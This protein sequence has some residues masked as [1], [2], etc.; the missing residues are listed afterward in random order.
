MFLGRKVK[1]DLVDTSTPKGGGDKPKKDMKKPMII[2]GVVALLLVIFVVVKLVSGGG[3]DSYMSSMKAIFT[4]ELGTF[5]YVLNVQTGAEGTI[6]TSE[7]TPTASIDELEGAE[8]SDAEG[9]GQESKYEFTD[10][11]KYAEVQSG[12]WEY[13]VF[14]IIIEGCTTSVEPLATHFTVSL[15]TPYSNDKFTD[16]T[17]FNGNYYIDVEQM[18]SWL[19]N[20]KD[21]YLTELGDALPQGSKYLIIPEAEFSIPSR[22]AE[23]GEKDFSNATGL[24]NMYQRFLVGYKTF[25][26]QVESAAG[27]KAFSTGDGTASMNISGESG[28]AVLNALKNTVMKVGDFHTSLVNASGGLY[29]EQQKQQAMRETDNI[30]VAFNDFNALLNTS[31]FSAAK[32]N[33][34]GFSRK[35]QNGNGNSTI[36]GNAVISFVLGGTDYHIEVNAMR[37]GDRTDVVLP[38]GSTLSLNDLEQMGDRH[39][40]LNTLNAIVDYFNFT[41]IKLS[42]ELDVT[43]ES[44]TLGAKQS[45]VDLVN[46]LEVYDGYLT[47]HNLPEYL[48]KY[49]NYEETAD[50]S[51]ADIMNAKLVADFVTSLNNVTGGLVIETVVEKEVEVEQYPE[52]MFAEQGIEFTLK[53]DEELSSSNM[54]V[55]NG[56]AINKGT[57][58]LQVDLT[59][60]SLHTLLSSVY[61][62]NNA[63]ILHDYD[64]SF[65]TESLD[66]ILEMPQGKWAQFTLYF[67]ISDDNGHMDLFLGGAQKGAVV[68]Y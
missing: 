48:E 18:R 30:I 3:K 42:Q 5:K 9:E 1:D 17:C 40:V 13:P 12:D 58:D 36:E 61:P 21:S 23:A 57:S 22:Y 8:S 19:V 49:M 16:V 31:D 65:D 14:Q 44:I 46:E 52:L 39:I 53:Y 4:N 37:S 34:S 43:P 7:T 11:N 68:E 45:F 28:V 63:T 20:S 47:M 29:S 59:M 33:M 51:Q 41:P 60:F 2:G 66:L 50:S 27:K 54:I 35:F 6:L 26:S 24:A 64:N 55:L 56:E 67:V 32:L 15:A 38:N 10:W 25:L 62:A